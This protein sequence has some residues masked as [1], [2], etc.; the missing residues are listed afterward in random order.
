ML[1]SSRV[2]FIGMLAM[3]F[4]FGMHVQ[5]IPTRAAE[6]NGASLSILDFG[7]RGDGVV[8][9]TPALNAA[10]AAAMPRSLTVRFPCGTFR[11]VSRPDPI[12]TGI[13]LI[14]C[15]SVGSTP[16]Y[17]SSLIA[18]YDETSPEEA[19]LVWNGSYSKA[20]AGCC[21]GT[22]GGVER[23]SVFKGA[24]KRG[25]TALKFSGIDDAHRAGYSTI[26][27]VLVGSVGGGNWQHDL[28][29]DGSCCRTPDT[30]GIRDT[31][32]NNFWAAQAVAPDQSVLF[33]SAVQVFWHGGEIM[34]AGAGANSGITIT[35]GDEVSEQ[36]ANIFISDVYIVGNLA[37]S[38]SRVVSFRGYVGGNATIQASARKV[39][40]AGLVGGRITNQSSTSAI[41]TNEL[42]APSATGQVTARI[43]RSGANSSADLVGTCTARANSCSYRFKGTYASHPI[44]VANDETTKTLAVEIVYTGATSVTFKHSG[45]E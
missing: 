35:G 40:L 22:G 11:F 23:I 18:D 14:G 33:R 2:L 5:R 41:E 9:N 1:K 20:H 45:T 42:I 21:A 3:A 7:G 38:Y 19:F 37:V 31:Y 28:I 26:S 4:M 39:I 44:C 29:I 8:D 43:L 24:R 36:S 6:E 12:G 30:Q 27:D 15:G 32:I 13:R 34:P 25:G 10:V 17:G 16:G